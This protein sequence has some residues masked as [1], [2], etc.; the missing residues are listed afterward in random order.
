M[1]GDQFVHSL[2]LYV[3]DCGSGL[4][5]M[6]FWKHETI[7]IS[8]SSFLPPCP[9]LHTAWRDQAGHV[10]PQWLRRITVLADLIRWLSR[11]RRLRGLIHE[12]LLSQPS[13]RSI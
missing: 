10:T 9:L 12:S 1:D 2:V 4:G 6:S 7:L 5:M 13:P 3:R 11:L 8:A